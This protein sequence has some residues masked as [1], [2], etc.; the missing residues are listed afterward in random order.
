MAVPNPVFLREG[1]LYSPCYLQNEDLSW[2]NCT[3]LACAM[4]MDCVTHGRI[5]ISGCSVRNQTHDFE[6][7]TSLP[8]NKDV[9]A[10]YGIPMEVHTGSAV[11]SPFYAFY[12]NQDGRPVIIQGN[13]Q[14][15]GRGNVNHA[16]L[17]LRSQG[18]EPGSPTEH[19]ILDPWSTG[20][21]QWSTG[22]L[23]AF[24]AALRPYGQ[25]D[26]RTLGP[27]KVY[28]GIFP[29]ADLPD[30]PEYTFHI[31]RGA[32]LRHYKMQKAQPINCIKSWTD[33]VWNR[34]AS[35]VGCTKPVRR[36]TC[37]G[38]S[39]ALTVKILGGT[40]LLDEYMLV[41]RGT[42]VTVRG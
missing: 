5:R 15:D 34:K 33:S 29:D 13:T 10:L 21:A 25:D 18:G 26:P 7:G 24:M 40:L 9:A 19:T 22:K 17:L 4:G 16:I 35:Q 14:P 3:C 39:S 23:K 27:G 37:D 42:S 1:T 2:K 31:A 38:R 36:V 28:C 32:K 41:G 30:G 8:Q 20:P 11:C 12:Q 6:G